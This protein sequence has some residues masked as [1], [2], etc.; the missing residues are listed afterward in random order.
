[1]KRIRHSPGQTA[2]SHDTRE[3]LSP[4]V[5]ALMGLVVGGLS[6]APLRPTR[7]VRPVLR[8][9]RIELDIY[10]GLVSD[11]AGRLQPLVRRL[12]ANR[13]ELVPGHLGKNPRRHS[14]GGELPPGAGGG[15]DLNGLRSAILPG[16]WAAFRG[17]SVVEM[18]ALLR[19]VASR[20]WLAKFRRPDSLLG[21]SR[22]RRLSPADILILSFGIA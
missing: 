10:R 15:D 19:A 17:L 22:L 21:A 6:V 11:S 20:T 12:D 2:S 3:R 5:V 8:L 16:P 13:A 9:K 14:P 1:M 4:S 18:A 7:L